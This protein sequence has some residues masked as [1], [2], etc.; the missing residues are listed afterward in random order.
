MWKKQVIDLANEVISHL[1]EAKQFDFDLLPHKAQFEEI[2]AEAKAEAA[3]MICED[4][5]KAWP[6]R[7]EHE[8]G[9]FGLLPPRGFY[10]GE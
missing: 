3:R 8:W 1:T 6:E 2:R 9:Q 4:N 10:T 7:A 5:W